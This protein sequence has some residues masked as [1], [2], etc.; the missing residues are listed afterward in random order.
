ML[1]INLVLLTRSVIFEFD[2]CVCV[3][4]CC[5]KI[6]NE[7]FSTHGIWSMRVYERGLTYGDLTADV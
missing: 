2:M 1:S 3:C 7:I 4:R 5:G 6:D